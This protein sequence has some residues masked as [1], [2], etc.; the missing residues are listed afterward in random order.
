MPMLQETIRDRRLKSL[1]VTHSNWSAAANCHKRL[2]A[3]AC[4]TDARME[5]AV[6]HAI[7]TCAGNELLCIR[8]VDADGPFLQVHCGRFPSVVSVKESIGGV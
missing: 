2:T 3:P 6:S 8:S 7:V 5:A 1:A 4:R